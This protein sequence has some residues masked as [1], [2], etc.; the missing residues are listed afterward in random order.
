MAFIIPTTT[1]ALLLLPIIITIIIIVVVVVVVVV[2]ERCEGA[3]FRSRRRELRASPPAATA[4]AVD[5]SAE[6]QWGAASS[7]GEGATVAA[8]AIHRNG[9]GTAVE[10]ALFVSDGADDADES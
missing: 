1:I 6:G 7:H 5:F 8:C 4:A 3:S 9:Q 10:A 2:L